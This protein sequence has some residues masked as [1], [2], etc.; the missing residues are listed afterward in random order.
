MLVLHVQRTWCSVRAASRAVAG[1]LA[2]LGCRVVLNNLQNLRAVAAYSVVLY[3]CLRHFVIP[4]DPISH[5]YLDLASGGV[6]LFFVISGFVMVYT[7]PD[8]EKPFWF[9]TKRIARIVPLYWA[10]TALVISMVLVREW[11]FPNVR[12]TPEAI[13]SSLFFIPHADA[14]GSIFPVLGVGWTLNYEMMFYALFTISLFLPA[15][16][17]L[18]AVTAL[19][20]VVWLI[21]TIA[22]MASTTV[23]ATFYAQPIIFEFAAGC[24]IAHALRVPRVIAFVRATPMWP[25][26]L[27]GATALL[28]LPLFVTSATPTLFKYGAPATLIVF[29]AAAQDLYRAPARTTFLTRLGDASYSAYLLHPIVI[30]LVSQLALLTVGTGLLAEGV[31]IVG[32]FGVTAIVSLL[33]MRY[34]EKPTAAY[35]RNR[36]RPKQASHGH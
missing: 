23:P 6:D 15:A 17:R 7:T 26:A 10:A 33:S 14:S 4:S 22:N 13:F 21:A 30:V 29:A 11:I 20:T 9:A 31:I 16:W 8:N 25:I 3:H 35:I 24:M 2:K 18:A 19:I 36:M 28:I 27:A 34:F 12:L 5:N 1:G 32:T